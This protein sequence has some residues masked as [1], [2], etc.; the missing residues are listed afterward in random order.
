MEYQ[1]FGR[2]GA[3]N[4]YSQQDVEAVAKRA[5]EVQ[6]AFHDQSSMH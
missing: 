2:G 4:F 6:N 3:G 5:T 1:K